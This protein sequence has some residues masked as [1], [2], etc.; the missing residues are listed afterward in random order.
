MP[1]D[2]SIIQN[3]VLKKYN[4]NKELASALAP[5]SFEEIE[6]GEELYRNIVTIGLAFCL[7]ALATGVAS[8]LGAERFF[9]FNEFVLGMLGYF[10]VG[11][12]SRILSLLIFFYSALN[13]IIPL[14]NLRGYSATDVSVTFLS[15]IIVIISFQMMRN[16]FRYHK[17][18]N[19]QV[20]FKNVIIKS[21]LT[22]GYILIFGA[23]LHL[24][25]I[26][27]T[28]Q[29][30][31]FAK[32]WLY[33]YLFIMA[34][35]LSG[36]FPFTKNRSMVA[37]DSRL[38]HS[39]YTP[40]FKSSATAVLKESPYWYQRGVRPWDKYI[41]P[42][43]RLFARMFDMIFF[44]ILLFCIFGL[45]SYHFE[46]SLFD[47]ILWYLQKYPGI[48]LMIVIPFIM[49]FINAFSLGLT[50]RTLGKWI[51]DIQ[52]TDNKNMPLTFKCALKRELLVWITGFCFGIPLLFIIPFIR[53]YNKLLDGNKTFWDEKL[54]L[55]II[56]IAKFHNLLGSFAV[57]IIFLILLGTLWDM[58]VF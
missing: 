54:N 4:D 26:A 9:I 37:F 13:L 33:G 55:K 41:D 11:Y 32:H 48:L 20:I 53:S 5:D 50:G 47:K 27:G 16:T 17:L 34:L 36:Y 19:S 28:I 46:T 31:A 22:A 23:C 39:S 35:S 3:R 2:F 21:L 10:T 8:L 52:I 25:Y 29:T 24:L 51:F 18:L 1:K 38:R 12:Q 15:I 58:V 49:I 44:G 43:K 42:W 45:L 14:F 56:Y 57:L 6:T 40:G 7:I 30:D